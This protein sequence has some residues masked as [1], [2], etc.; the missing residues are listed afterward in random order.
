MRTHLAAINGILEPHALLDKRMTG[1]AH[2]RYADSDLHH[3]N[4]V[5]GQPWVMNNFGAWFS[6]QKC[7]AQLDYQVL[8]LNERAGFIEEEAAVEVSIPGNTEIGV[9]LAH[10]LY[11]GGAVLR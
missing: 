10:C 6:L 8:P 2:H 7:L 1:L 5:P 9:M 3:I 4:G 11:S